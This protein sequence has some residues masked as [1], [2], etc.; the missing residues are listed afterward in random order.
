MYISEELLGCLDIS[1]NSEFL[2]VKKHSLPKLRETSPPKKNELLKYKGLV[3]NK[4]VTV[5]VDCGATM[6]FVSQSVANT[7]QGL[8]LHPAKTPI[9]VALAN[10]NTIKTKME[11]RNVVLQLGEH[12]E[13]RTLHVL[14]ME[15]IQIVLGKPWLHDA[16]PVIDWR[17]HIMEIV[18]Y[19]KRH[20]IHPTAQLAI[21][22]NFNIIQHN[23]FAQEDNQLVAFVTA[24]SPEAMDDLPENADALPLDNNLHAYIC[25]LDSVS[26]VESNETPAAYAERT[27][28]HFFKPGDSGKQSFPQDCY[29][30]LLGHLKKNPE[31]VTPMDPGKPI[32]RKIG[33]APPVEMEIREEKGS[34]PQCKQPYRMSPLELKELRKQL[35]HLLKAGYIRPSRSPYGAPVLFA[36]KK[37]GA[38]RLCLDYRALNAQ[39]IKDKYPL[40]RDTDCFDQFV[41][42]NYF[43][44]I[45][46]LNGYWVVPIAEN[47]IHKTA[48]R[49]P[50][51]SFEW[52]VMPF[53]LTNAP[54]V[55]QRMI[56]GILEEFRTEFVM[57]FIDDICIYTKGDAKQ[58]LEHVKKVLDALQK[59]HIKIKLE[60]CHFFMTEVE[61]LGHIVNGKELKPDPA[62]IKAIQEWPEPETA[63]QIQQFVGL[64]GYYQRMIHNFAKIAAPLTDV[65]ALKCT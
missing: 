29:D 62:K 11:A 63:Q 61:Y 7:L 12:M 64:V 45:D 37:N 39:T 49:T 18:S 23:Q 26:K 57:V 41:G 44:T 27:F 48:I 52:L 19:G 60:K 54:S 13:T 53:G 32:T 35:D 46:N 36:P 17:A 3:N 21:E 38:L 43:T 30:G 47:S 20:V 2:G 16:M 51:G 9:N 10:G 59:H 50:L 25:N 58:H 5:L 31:L 22:E 28:K 33:T 55:Y 42:A 6:D 24:T 4:L 14:P 65:M 1:E 56:E 40:P 15:N 34:V 8:K